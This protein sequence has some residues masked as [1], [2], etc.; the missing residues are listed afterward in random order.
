[1]RKGSDIDDLAIVGRTAQLEQGGRELTFVTELAVGIVLD[2]ERFAFL[3]RLDQPLTPLERQGCALRVLKVGNEVKQFWFPGQVLFNFFDDE[4]I[5]VR[6]QRD[7]LSA[8]R[9]PGEQES[10]V[11]GVFDEGGV[12]FIDESAADEIERLL[13]AGDNEDIVALDF[14]TAARELPGDVIAE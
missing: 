6:S 8:E 5:L 2:Q 4:A 12:A 9:A 7:E 1:F 3:D 11:S 10:E 14:E 13:T